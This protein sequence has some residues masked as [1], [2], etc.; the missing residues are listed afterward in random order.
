MQGFSLSQAKSTKRCRKTLRI[1]VV[2]ID[3]FSTTSW[4]DAVNMD[5]THQ[6]PANQPFGAALRPLLE[7]RPEFLT[8]TGNI[9]W[10]SVADAMPD[11]NYESL[12]KALTGERQPSVSLMERAAEV[13]GIEP[14]QFAEYRLAQARRQFDPAEV[15]WDGAIENLARL[16]KNPATPG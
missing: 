8:K 12:R 10:A 14:S 11:T 16:A 1:C 6:S 9:N 7:Q 2:P 4:K 5:N 3:H 15:G 13:A